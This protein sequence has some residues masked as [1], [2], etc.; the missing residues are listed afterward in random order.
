MEFIPEQ[1]KFV[2]YESGHSIYIKNQCLC[3]NF[4]DKF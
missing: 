3:F 1:N 2:Q 4:D